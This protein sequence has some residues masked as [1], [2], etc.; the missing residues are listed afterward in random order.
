MALIETALPYIAIATNL[1]YGLG[2][3]YTS[4]WLATHPPSRS[5][6]VKAAL[7]AALIFFTLLEILL[8]YV[9]FDDDMLSFLLFVLIAVIHLISATV[10]W[11]FYYKVKNR[12]IIP[13]KLGKRIKTIVCLTL[14]IPF[15]LYGIILILR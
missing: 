12:E 5:I 13:E 6:T 7:Y 2:C 3:V 9:V 15:L 1:I 11:P 8:L 4:F 10:L 14:F